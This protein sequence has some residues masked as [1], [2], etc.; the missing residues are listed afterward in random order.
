MQRIMQLISHVLRKKESLS[1][2]R[3]ANATSQKTT[4]ITGHKR[5]LI[6]TIARGRR[7][8]EAGYLGPLATMEHLA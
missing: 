8:Y 7:S 1:G 3:G 4:L 5:L 2:W 6:I